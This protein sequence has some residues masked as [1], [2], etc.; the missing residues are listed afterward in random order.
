MELRHV[1]ERGHA[2]QVC[3]PNPKRPLETMQCYVAEMFLLDTPTGPALLW[4]GP[5]WHEYPP[6]ESCCICYAQPLPDASGKR[7]VDNRPRHGN[8]CLDFFNPVVIEQLDAASEAWGE[9]ALWSEKKRLAS[10]ALDRDAAWSIAQAF[11]G[12]MHYQRML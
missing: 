2:L 3:M 4:L 5:D 6:G 1:V 8:K 12:D 11:L 10:P 9:H 7:W